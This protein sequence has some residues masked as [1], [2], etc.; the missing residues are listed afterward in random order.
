MFLTAISE[1]RGPTSDYVVVV[2][3]VI[4]CADFFLRLDSASFQTAF[5]DIFLS[6]DSALF[7]LL[8][9]IFSSD[10]IPHHFRLHLRIFSLDQIP[11]FENSDLGLKSIEI[12]TR[13]NRG[14]FYVSL[15]SVPISG[16]GKSEVGWALGQL[17]SAHCPSALPVSRN[18]NFDR[19]Q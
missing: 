9:R 14:N 8:S 19:F 12:A 17:Y 5:E 7:K 3:V 18:H 1:A 6:S 16:G 11:H 4:L 15:I 13:T 10:Q 2:L